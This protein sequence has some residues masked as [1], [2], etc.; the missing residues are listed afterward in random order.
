MI[1]VCYI[2]INIISWLYFCKPCN[3]IHHTYFLFNLILSPLTLL[4]EK[5]HC[6]LSIQYPE[7]T[8]KK[9]SQIKKKMTQSHG[10]LNQ[11]K[12]NNENQEE[13]GGV[14]SC[15]H[16]SVQLGWKENHNLNSRLY[17]VHISYLFFAESA[18]KLVLCS[19]RWDCG[20]RK[21]FWQTDGRCLGAHTC[22]VKEMQGQACLP[23]ALLAN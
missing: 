23:I 1:I 10:L 16:D 22:S 4:Y 18:S 8:E 6:S 21:G 15:I 12:I 11:F 13:K 3:Q 17:S 19:W 7:T 9:G 14:S 2:S 20:L 5:L